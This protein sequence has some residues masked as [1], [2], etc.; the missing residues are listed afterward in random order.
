MADKAIAELEKIKKIEL[1]K[2][3][4]EEI[5]AK[6]KAETILELKKLKEAELAR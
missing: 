1:K 4:N 2:K 6:E 5:K 3:L